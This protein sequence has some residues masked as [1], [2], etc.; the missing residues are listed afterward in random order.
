MTLSQKTHLEASERAQPLLQQL[1]EAKMNFRD[2]IFFLIGSR[3]LDDTASIDDIGNLVA[4]NALTST[5]PFVSD[6]GQKLMDQENRNSQRID[7]FQKL[8][9]NPEIVEQ[10]RN[11]LHDKIFAK[12]KEKVNNYLD[13]IVSYV[14]AHI[15]QHIGFIKALDEFVRL[16][17][18]AYSPWGVFT[19]SEADM[20]AS[21]DKISQCKP[22]PG[23]SVPLSLML[24]Q[25]YEKSTAWKE[26]NPRS[27]LSVAWLKSILGTL[28]KYGTIE[29]ELRKEILKE[30]K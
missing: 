11:E 28:M 15:D 21:L 8:L 13:L 24:I 17:E 30:K 18:K 19:V 14:D 20:Q 10:A 25:Q 29:E 16:E 23:L 5:S 6:A 12:D 2:Q 1:E 9:N 22:S 27:N 4:L 7:I 3:H 26:H